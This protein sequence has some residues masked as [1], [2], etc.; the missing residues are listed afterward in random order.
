ML[1]LHKLKD[2]VIKKQHSL[3]NL[4]IA[5]AQAAYNGAKTGADRKLIQTNLQNLL[6]KPPYNF[7]P[8]VSV[9]EAKR[10]LGI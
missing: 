6:Q 4:T 8:S 10:L 9:D 7:S 5:N 2:K 1:L 3:Q